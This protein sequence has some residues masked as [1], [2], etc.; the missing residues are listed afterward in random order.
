[1]GNINAIATVDNYYC[2]HPEV[3]RSGNKRYKY[4]KYFN[5]GYLLIKQKNKKESTLKE[6]YKKQPYLRTVVFN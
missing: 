3:L 4:I 1:M 6:K 5:G 2:R